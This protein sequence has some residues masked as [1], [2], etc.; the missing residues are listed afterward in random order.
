[1]FAAGFVAYLMKRYG[2]PVVPLILGL[3]LGGIIE[4]NFRKALVLSDGSLVPFVTN[5]FVVVLLM[6]A[7]VMLLA[8][9]VKPWLAARRTRSA[10]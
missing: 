1:M 6:L 9:I 2:F 10:S 8:P 7:L 3:V 5:P 4:D